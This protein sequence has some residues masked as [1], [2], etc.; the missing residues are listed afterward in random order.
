MKKFA[1][2]AFLVGIVGTVGIAGAADP[3]PTGTWKWEMKR[4]GKG[5]DEVT[6]EQTMKLELK[7]G[8]LTGTVSGGGFGGKGG[9]GKGGGKGGG[10]QKIDEG[11]KYDKG[12]FT[13]T[14]TREFGD[15]KFVT[16]YSGKVADDTI[17]MTITTMFNDKENKTEVEA[18]R[19]KEEK[20]N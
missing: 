8:K 12:E 7:D 16:K 5:G 17:K 10:A 15:N 20:K 13:F 19:V 14:T 9:G 6:V 1:V 3:D 18:K 2:V 11:A 4:K